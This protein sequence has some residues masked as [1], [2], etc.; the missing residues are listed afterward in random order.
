MLKEKF[1]KKEEYEEDWK[2]PIKETL[3]REEDVAKLKIVKDYVLMKGKLYRRMLGVILSRCVGYE[4]A[5][6]KL[7]EVH[8]KTCGFYKEVSLY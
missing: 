8:S 2:A 4:E 6:R 7:E 3:L 1:P 5:Q